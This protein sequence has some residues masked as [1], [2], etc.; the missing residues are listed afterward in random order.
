MEALTGGLLGAW[1]CRGQWAGLGLGASLPPEGLDQH[2]GRSREPSDL[3][4]QDS[5]EE[6][7]SG[8]SLLLQLGRWR[9]VVGMR[10]LPCL[11]SLVPA[12]LGPGWL[13]RD[14]L[15]KAGTFLE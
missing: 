9:P 1:K 13:W 10:T 12:P 15:P 7:R 5:S 14:T 6:S 8:Q 11:F 2:V 3:E 4:V